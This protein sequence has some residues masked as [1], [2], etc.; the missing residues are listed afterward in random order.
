MKLSRLVLLLAIAFA[1]AGCVV[2][3]GRPR[4]L[5]NTVASACLEQNAAWRSLTLYCARGDKIGRPCPS[6]VRNEAG[7]IHK[8]ARGFCLATHPDT[9]GN[10]AK[11]RAWRDRLQKLGRRP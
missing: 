6:E 4:V 10:I 7:A 2:A 5:E 11:V 1:V 8:E 3:G 9:A